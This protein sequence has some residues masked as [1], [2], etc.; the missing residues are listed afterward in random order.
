MTELLKNEITERDCQNSRKWN[1][2]DW[3][4]QKLNALIFIHNNLIFQVISGPCNF[5]ILLLEPKPF[6][7]NK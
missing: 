4:L 6:F 7:I 3:K 5:K 2:S 1:L